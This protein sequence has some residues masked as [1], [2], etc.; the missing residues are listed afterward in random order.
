MSVEIK[1]LKKH[2]AE[3]S[4]SVFKGAPFTPFE[5]SMTFSPKFSLFFFSTVIKMHLIQIQDFFHKNMHVVKKKD[6]VDHKAFKL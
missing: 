2:F 4:F 3:K 5:H 1:I 6:I